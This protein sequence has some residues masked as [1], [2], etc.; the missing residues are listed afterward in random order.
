MESSKLVSLVHQ[1]VYHKQLGE[2]LLDFVDEK[3]GW[4]YVKYKEGDVKTY[5]TEKFSEYFSETPFDNEEQ[6]KLESEESAIIPPAVGDIQKNRN[7]A[8][9]SKY[10]ISMEKMKEILYKNYVRCYEL[11]LEAARGEK[12]TKDR[13]EQFDSV[14]RYVKRDD[15]KQNR[16]KMIYQMAVQGDPAAIFELCTFNRGEAR[17]FQEVF[18]CAFDPSVLKLFGFPLDS[19]CGQEALVIGALKN[20]LALADFRENREKVF[21]G[22]SGMYE[23]DATWE[24]IEKNILPIATPDIWD[25]LDQFYN[26]ADSCV[27]SGDKQK[28]NEYCKM[29]ESERLRLRPRVNPC[30]NDKSQTD[31]TSQPDEKHI[32]SIDF[33]SIKSAQEYLRVYSQFQNDQRTENKERTAT[34]KKLMALAFFGLLQFSD[35][36]GYEQ[37]IQLLNQ[38]DKASKSQIQWLIASI[39]QEDVVPVLSKLLRIWEK[40][41]ISIRR[42]WFQA[43]QQQMLVD[44]GSDLSEKWLE[45]LIEYNILDKVFCAS[46]R[47][48]TLLKPAW[49]NKVIELTKKKCPDISYFVMIGCRVW[50]FLQKSGANCD[51][52]ALQWMSSMA[53]CVSDATTLQDGSNLLRFMCR[54]LS[55][56]PNGMSSLSQCLYRSMKNQKGCDEV[57]RY[58]QGTD[59]TDLQQNEEEK[60]AHIKAQLITA[61]QGISNIEKRAAELIDAKRDHD[62]YG[63]AIMQSVLDYRRNIA[64]FIEHQW[65]NRLE[66]I[67]T[68]TEF[69]NREAV[70]YKNKLHEVK[71]S[72]EDFTFV[73]PMTMGIKL[74]DQVIKRAQVTPKK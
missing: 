7:S 17:K 5:L 48:W 12:I 10:Q 4:F 24:F 35:D 3:R 63:M 49:V 46:D 44:F 45:L 20:T 29:H 25:S 70:L 22:P 47:F 15:E 21:C 32:E 16:Q 62:G 50:D 14:L 18:A 55:K 60:T 53:D 2:G 64:Y 61:L 73:I 65:G 26:G 67:I 69:L 28:Y 19:R 9:T 30:N 1:K 57:K 66:S 56:S 37:S 59:T 40:N 23:E 74:D 39:P 52:I 6:P 11:F 31:D 36:L 27:P 33:W 51:P 72:G 34:P 43:F 54:E 38:L 41:N 8:D 42:L 58:E 71:E 13:Y 68:P